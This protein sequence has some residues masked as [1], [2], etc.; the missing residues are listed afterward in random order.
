LVHW[1][2]GQMKLKLSGEPMVLFLDASDEL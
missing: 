1:V 2:A